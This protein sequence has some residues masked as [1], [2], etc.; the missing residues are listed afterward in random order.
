[1]TRNNNLRN[2]LD[3]QFPE[4]PKWDFINTTQVISPVDNPDQKDARGRTNNHLARITRLHPKEAQE[5]KKSPIVRLSGLRV[6]C[7]VTLML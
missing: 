4:I 5:K 3:I 1:M 6:L 2:A 7:T